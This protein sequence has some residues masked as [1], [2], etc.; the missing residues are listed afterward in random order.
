MVAV[1][2]DYTDDDE[3][4]LVVGAALA[5]TDPPELA[6]LLVFDDEELVFNGQGLGFT[7]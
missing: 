1:Y 2:R 5:M 6:E 4:F 3:W 7:Q